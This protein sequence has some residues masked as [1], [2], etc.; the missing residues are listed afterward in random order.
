MVVQQIQTQLTQLLSEF[1]EQVTLRPN[2]IFVVGCST[3][4]VIGQKIGT[5]GALETAEAIFEPLLTFAKKHQLHLAFQGC[6]HINRAITMEA[7]IAE[8]FGYEPVAV[9]PIRTAGGS[10]SAYAYTQ[11]VEPVV[12]ET[13]IGNAGIDIGQTLIGMHLKHVAV[14]VRTSVRT[15][16]EAVVTIATTRPKRIGGERAVYK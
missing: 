12:V 6:E 14:P 13:V 11:F 8:Q 9:V 2:T 3:S 16:G 10:M 15:V 5:A 4:E 7:A 1:E